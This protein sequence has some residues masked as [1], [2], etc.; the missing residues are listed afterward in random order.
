MHMQL[1]VP[2][3]PN[4]YLFNLLWSLTSK[5][6]VQRTASDM[7]DTEPTSESASNRGVGVRAGGLDSTSLLN[8]IGKWFSKN[9][10]EKILLPTVYTI[11]K[12]VLFFILS[13]VSY[14]LFY[15]W[16]VPKALASEPVYFD[17]DAKPPTAKINMLSLE[18]QWAYTNKKNNIQMTNT[19]I[20][21]KSSTSFLRSD[22]VYQIDATFDLSKNRQN[23]D[24]GKFM[25]YLAVVDTTGASIAKSARPVPIPYQSEMTLW[26]D[27]ICKYPFRVFGFLSEHETARVEVPLMNSYREPSGPAAASSE[28]LELSLSNSLPS[29]GISGVTVTVMPVLPFLAYYMYYWPMICAIVG[30]ILFTIV[31]ILLYMSYLLIS[32]ALQAVNDIENE[33]ENN[34]SFVSI[35]TH[36]AM[37]GTGS[38]SG[39]RD[40]VSDNYENDDEDE[41]ENEDDDEDDNEDDDDEDVT[42]SITSQGQT[43]VT[44]SNHSKRADTDIDADADAD[45]NSQNDPNSPSSATS[46]SVTDIINESTAIYAQIQTQNGDNASNSYSGSGVDIPIVQEGSA[47]ATNSSTNNDLRQRYTKI[48]RS[49]R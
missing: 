6:N 30:I 22:F 35:G 23:Y 44:G 31:Q 18:K 28:T 43:S 39:T 7:S 9:W 16:M 2:H 8:R 12:I 25:V 46:N 10:F 37:T 11:A 4:I 17:Y 34:G 19:N 36:T 42:P 24:L 1:Y 20:D 15:R 5:L 41:N 14:T 13:L 38:R 26:L 3:R 27:A 29:P 40:D 33:S 49:L 32:F 45:W 21:K 47:D 48:A